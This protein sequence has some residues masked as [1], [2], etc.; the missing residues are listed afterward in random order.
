MN[1]WD[2]VSFSHLAKPSTKAYADNYDRIFN[3]K[4]D[5]DKN[6]DAECK[7]GLQVK[8]VQD[9]KV[10]GLWRRAAMAVKAWL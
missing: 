5:A 9:S 3:K 4:K 6:K 7:W 10:Q 1:N 8:K 2:W